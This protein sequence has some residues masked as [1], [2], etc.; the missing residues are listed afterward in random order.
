ML[1]LA[2][3]LAALRPRQTY[4]QSYDC[5]EHTSLLRDFIVAFGANRHGRFCPT[6]HSSDAAWPR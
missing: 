3:K 2:L 6:C 5:N 1:V 4:P